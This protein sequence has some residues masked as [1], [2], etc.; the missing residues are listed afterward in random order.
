MKIV[1]PSKISNKMI[2][3]ALVAA[4]ISV[5]FAMLSFRGKSMSAIPQGTSSPETTSDV[6]SKTSSSPIALGGRATATP[7]PAPVSTPASD[8]KRQAIVDETLR[9]RHRDFWAS[10]FEIRSDQL[11]ARVTGTVRAYGGGKDD[12]ILMIIDDRD[13][14]NF[15]GGNDSPAQEKVRV[16]GTRNIYVNL[17]PGI[18]HIVLSNLHAKFFRKFVDAKLYLEYN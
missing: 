11:N 6:L 17:K 9:L 12:V 4:I 2:L 18:Y 14:R 15:S 1:I 8:N 7:S 13:Y 16:Y 3:I 5:A 10:R